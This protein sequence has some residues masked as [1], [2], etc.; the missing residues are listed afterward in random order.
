MAH[1]RSLNAALRERFGEKLCKLALDGGFTFVLLIQ[2]DT[3]IGKNK[4]H[5]F[6][7]GVPS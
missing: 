6:E 4:I 2:A 5:P 1:Y 3:H 7:Q